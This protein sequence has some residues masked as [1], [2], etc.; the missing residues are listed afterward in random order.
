MGLL[1]LYLYPYINI[2]VSDGLFLCRCLLPK[3]LQLSSHSHYTVREHTL[4]LHG[5]ESICKQHFL[6][7]LR[8]T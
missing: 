7:L 5:L 8:N 6:L 1:Y 4:L 2:T 3:L